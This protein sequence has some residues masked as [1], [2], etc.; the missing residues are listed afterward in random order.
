MLL[1]CSQ[2]V[3]LAKVVEA[4]DFICCALQRKTN[5]KVALAKATTLLWFRKEMTLISDF[6]P[7]SPVNA[8]WFLVCWLLKSRIQL[9]KVNNTDIILRHAILSKCCQDQREHLFFVFLSTF[10]RCILGQTDQIGFFFFSSSPPVFRFAL[11]CGTAAHSGMY[12][13]CFSSHSSKTKYLCDCESMKIII[14]ITKLCET[15]VHFS[16]QKA[17]LKPSSKSSENT[18][19]AVWTELPKCHKK[20]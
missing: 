19:L 14:I 5:S 15:C 11:C 8:A 17:F 7:P 18:E 12:V 20:T 10:L 2:G 1:L 16:C 4:G 6:F 9:L 13:E 3:N